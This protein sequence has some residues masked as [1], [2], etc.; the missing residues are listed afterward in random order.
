MKAIKFEVRRVVR[1]NIKIVRFYPERDFDPSL[2]LKFEPKINGLAGNDGVANFERALRMIAGLQ[3]EEEKKL[4]FASGLDGDTVYQTAEDRIKALANRE[5]ADPD[6]GWSLYK[7]KGQKTFRYLHDTYGV[8]WIEFLRRVMRG[9]DDRRYSLCFVHQN[10]GMWKADI[11]W[12]GSN[13][14]INH[15]ALAFG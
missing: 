7:E 12:L 9:V 6:L 14:S 2:G 15:P 5:L 3:R 11:S 8:T 4:L 1:F 10:D 13:R